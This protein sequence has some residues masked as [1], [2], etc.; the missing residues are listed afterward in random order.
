MADQDVGKA[1][2]VAGKIALVTGGASGIGAATSRLLA[3]EGATVYVADINA[4]GGA[5]VAREIGGTFVTLDVSR[6]AG[7]QTVVTRLDSEQ[8]RL[9]ILVNNAGISP[10]DDYETLDLEAW[11]HIMDIVLRGPALGCKHGLALLKHSEAGAIVNLS[12][13]AG[14]IGSSGYASYG[15]A[16]AGVRNMSKSVALLCAERGYPVRCNSVH[17]GS[18]DTPILDDDRRKHGAKAITGRERLIPLKRLG[19]PEEVANAILFL[20]SEEASFITGTELI[21]DGGFTAR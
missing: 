8:G 12:S 11:D 17:P 18:I 9:D 5:A 4:E 2:R 19:R 3:A 15:A 7:W 13:I 10:H 6:E 1:G 20:A 21:V 16:K 14:M